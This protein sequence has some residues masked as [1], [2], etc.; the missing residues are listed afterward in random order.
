MQ[1]QG[2]GARVVARG[3]NKIDFVLIDMLLNNSWQAI[4]L[5]P[6]H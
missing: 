4:V 5:Q 2:L 1:G 3:Q 6:F